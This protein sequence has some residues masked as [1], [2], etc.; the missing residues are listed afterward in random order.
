MGGWK[1]TPSPPSSQKTIVV[2]LQPNRGIIV[3]RRLREVL[4]MW[5]SRR[6]IAWTS[7]EGP[8]LLLVQG[9]G[10]SFWK[11]ADGPTGFRQ[12]R[13]GGNR[14]VIVQLRCRQ[15]P[16]QSGPASAASDR[17][18]RHPSHEAVATGH[19]GPVSWAGG[20]SLPRRFHC[21]QPRF[22]ANRWPHAALGDEGA[23]GRA[24]P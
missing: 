9:T 22:P 8:W 14:G 16:G 15:R 1:A 10:A 2:N 3:A 7:F 18:T 4:P 24:F 17:G 23:H 13:G 11:L 20:R 12:D 5:A 6:E 21:S 19:P